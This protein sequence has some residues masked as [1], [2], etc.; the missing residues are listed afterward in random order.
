MR[1]VHHLRPYLAISLV[2]LALLALAPPVAAQGGGPPDY[3]NYF[4][5][6]S[7]LVVWVVAQ[8]HLL[9]AAFV[10]G[11]PI[12]A[13]ITEY[14]GYRSGEKRYDKLAHDFTKLLSAAF[15]TTAAFGGLL[16]F[17]LFALYPTFM[18]H[19]SDVF[20]PTFLWYG[21]LFFAEGFTMYFYLYSWKRLQGDR[22]KWH[23]WT[24]VFLNVFGVAIMLIAN[25]WVSYMMSPPLA[26][27]DAE[28]GEVVRQG[29][30]ALTLEWSGTLWQAINNPLW[31]P[32]NIHRTIGNVAFGGFIVGAY[33]AVR[34]LN[35][36]TAEAR[37]YYDW[38]GY[39]GNFIGVAALIPMPFA[40]YYMGRE[41]YSYSAVM[42]NNMMGGAFSWT[43]IIQAILIGALFI[44]ANFYLWSGMRRIPGSERYLKYI[45]WLDVV[46][47]ICFAIWLT[48]HN[49][50]L[51]PSEQVIMGGQ[52]HPTLKFLGL[53]A[54]K[55]AVI[56]FIIVATF[57]SFL[58]YRR[59]N[60]GERVPVSQQGAGA[61]IV[62][63]V[64]FAVVA[65]VLGWYAAGI[66][67]LNPD[68]LD[69]DASKGVY[70]T[71]VAV[72]LVVQ[73]VAGA[74][75]VGLTLTDRG[76]TGQLLYLATTVLN[77]VFI[78]GPYGFVV[79]TQANPF[80]RNIAV[81][82]W[83]ITMSSLVLVAAIDIVLLRGAK[84]IGAIRWGQM[85]GSSQYALILLVVGVVML[86]SLMGYIRSGLREDWH[87]F[88]ALRDTSASA[89]TPSMA[90]MARVIAGIVAA[91]MALIAFV[92]WLAGLGETGEVEEG[93][94]AIPPQP[95]PQPAAS[96]VP[97]D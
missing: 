10:L 72:L 65:L 4:G 44:G 75:A 60:K 50:P 78:L 29:L 51:S 25:S 9:F 15:S 46:L 36:K 77:S 35:S 40:G 18:S 57:M 26:E 8:L 69:L 1:K 79:M 45:K 42:G 47:I 24:G 30:N 55:N 97:S 94:M 62:V 76:V 58:F 86:M 11:V 71:L 68:T 59:G 22:K 32:L 80:L 37:A 5:A 70:F 87:I 91:F 34:F 61:K 21:L 43:F 54:A 89:L 28:T 39:I 64:A 96:T 6:D 23:L 49:L 88:G 83:L 48:P 12:F 95:T 31:S 14:V 7:R 56:N 2:L 90:Y 38:M 16:A 73:I 93:T 74:V 92:F 67:S 27:V 19:L 81:A 84:E 82:Q 63:L 66:F 41:V 3:R 33:A 20:S 52:F 17:S 53:M 85:A 13:V